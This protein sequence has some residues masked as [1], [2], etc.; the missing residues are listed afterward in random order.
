MTPA[1]LTL[2]LAVLGVLAVATGLT[3]L[4]VPLWVLSVVALVWTFVSVTP[5]R[6]GDS[7]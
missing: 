3:W 7:S 5:R 4:A 2:L 6:S 1:A